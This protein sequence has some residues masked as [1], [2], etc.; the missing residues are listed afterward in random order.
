VTTSRIPQFGPARIV[1]LSRSHTKRNFTLGQQDGHLV[2]RLQTSNTSRNGVDFKLAPLE[3]GK[4]CHLL[5][6]YKPG[7]LTCYLNGKIASQTALERG[8]FERWHGS[9]Y[10]LIFG[11]EVGGARPWE[12]LLDSVAIY[13][14]FIGPEEAAKKFEL[15][16]VRLA[17]RPKIDQKIVKAEMLDKA[18]SPPPESIAPY[19][20]ALVINRYKIKEAKDSHLVDQTVQVAEW[21]LLDAKIPSTY[22]QAKPS[23]VL[24]LELEP[25]EAHPQLESERLA[26]DMP[27]LDEDIYY[28][29]SSGR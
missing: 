23:Q 11:N 20:R 27:S 24:E 13:S 12:G 22:A 29:V 5:V 21:A 7:L 18:E 15:A 1:S 17:A 19:R 14:R 6:T 28:S 26:S 9:S 8:S 3:A 10:S 4:P 25:Y 16:G 2:L